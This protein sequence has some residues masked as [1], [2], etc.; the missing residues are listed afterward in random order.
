MTVWR[1]F[2]ADEGTSLMDLVVGM[3]IMSIFMAMFT[4]AVVMMNKTQQKSDELGQTSSQ[5][6]QAFLMLDRTVRYADAIS[7]PAIGTSGDWYVELRIPTPQ[8]D[9]TTVEK[10]TQLRVDIAKQQLQRRI[11]TVGATPPSTFAPVAS[12]IINGDSSPTSPKPFVP[13]ALSADMA[14]QRLTI[15]LVSKHGRGTKVTESHSSVTFTAVNSTVPPPS[16]AICGEPG[17][18]P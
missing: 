12:E 2:R 16:G 13:K 18:R 4:G 14:F 7:T 1:R 17:T 5:L 15:N 11:W 6:N 8:A 10:C 3:G 9:G